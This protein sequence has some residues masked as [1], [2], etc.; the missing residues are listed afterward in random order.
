MLCNNQNLPK[1]ETALNKGPDGVL[2]S[3]YFQLPNQ[4]FNK[5][6]NFT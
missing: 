6:S 4:I 5:D 3:K 2:A 1:I